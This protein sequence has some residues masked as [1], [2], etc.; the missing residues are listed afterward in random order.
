MNKII[1]SG[2]IAF[3]NLMTYPGVFRNSILPEKLDDINLSFLVNG[4]KK[5]RGGTAPNIAYSLALMN[6]ETSI[7]G[8]VGC[9][10]DGY[11]K[12]LNDN[13]VG[14]EYVKVLDNEYTA[15]CFNTT[16]EEANQLTFFY[17]G[18]MAFDSELSMKSIDTNGLYMVIIAPTDPGAME[19]WV[20]ECKEYNIPYLYDP[21]MQIPRIDKES[22]AFGILNSKI[23]VLNDYEYEMMKEKT[24]LSDIEILN[25]VDL[26]VITMGAKGSMLKRG[27]EEKFVKAAKIN[28]LVNPTGAGDAYRAGLLKGYIEGRSL[29][30][31]GKLASITAAYAV[32]FQGATEHKYSLDEFYTRYKENYE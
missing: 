10:F 5:Q 29:D 14:T 24:S 2:S 18:A 3:D 30:E 11:K 4:L 20:K 26:M 25:S 22:L 19:K 15:S 28:R 13:N 32:E 12:W 17:P 9:D 31:M 16:D 27:N 7:F 1:V 8:T 21:G 6:L 23:L